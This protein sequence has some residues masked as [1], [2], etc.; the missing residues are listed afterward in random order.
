[1]IQ[2]LKIINGIDDMNCESFLNL[3][4]MM[5]LE[6]LIANYIFN[7]LEHRVKKC[8]FS[9]RSAPV[10]NTKLSQKS[11]CCTNVDNFKTSR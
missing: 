10:W 7:M 9:R 3:L 4:I 11:K 1:M 6:I 2:V 5:V 8:T